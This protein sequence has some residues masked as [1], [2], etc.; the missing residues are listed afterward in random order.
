MRAITASGMVPTATEGRI[1]CHNPSQ[2]GFQLPVTMALMREK[3]E[4]KLTMNF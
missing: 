4:R 2:N 3:L 1:R